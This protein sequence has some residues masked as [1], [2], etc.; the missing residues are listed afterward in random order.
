MARTIALVA[1][2]RL[3]GGLCLSAPVLRKRTSNI[4]ALFD[5]TTLVTAD[6]ALVALVRLDE[7]AFPR[8]VGLPG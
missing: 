7:F 5:A 4:D 3:R 6:V 8:H 2:P 1:V